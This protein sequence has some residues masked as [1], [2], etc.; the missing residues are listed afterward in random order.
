MGL[1]ILTFISGLPL[2]PLPSIN[3]II[4]FL[5]PLLLLLPPSSSDVALVW[6]KCDDNRIRGFLVERGMEGFHTPKIEGKF[7]LRASITGLTLSLLGSV[8]RDVG[9]NFVLGRT[10]SKL[11]Q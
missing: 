10:N 3:C 1:N 9:E 4:L 7:S 6:A 5:L 2:Y 11:V 8:C